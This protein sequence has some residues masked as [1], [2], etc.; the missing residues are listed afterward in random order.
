MLHLI[1]ASVSVHYTASLKSMIL[2]IK[3][4]RNKPQ[5]LINGQKAST[6]LKMFKS[7]S[8][9]PAFKFPSLNACAL[10][11]VACSLLLTSCGVYTFKDV[12]IP[13]EVKTIKLS[14][15]ENK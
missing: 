8:L 5:A 7:W 14:Y 15:I 12:S 9:F 2:M 3:E 4:K 13:P 6:V 11:L 10:L 1:W